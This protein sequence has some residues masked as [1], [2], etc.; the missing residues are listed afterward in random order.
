MTELKYHGDI[1]N[2]TKKDSDTCNAKDIKEVLNFLKMTYGKAC[3]KEAERMLIVVN[4]TSIQLK[5]G[6][7]TTLSDNDTISF[8][9]VCGGG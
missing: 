9:P 6:F 5:N 7:K 2:L 4:G 8:L 1:K 3:A